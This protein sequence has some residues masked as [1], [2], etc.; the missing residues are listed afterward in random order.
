MKLN[1]IRFGETDNRCTIY[2]QRPL[3][4]RVGEYYEQHLSARVTWAEFVRI[5]LGICARL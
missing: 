4:C 3:V 5:N 1:D 2:A